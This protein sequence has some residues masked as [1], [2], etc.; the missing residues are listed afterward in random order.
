[1][2]QFYLMLAIAAVATYVVA[3][4]TANWLARPGFPLPPTDRRLGCVDGLRGYL[5]ISVFIHH[6][7][8]W[9]QASRPGGSWGPPSINILNQL[10]AGSVAL[11]FMTTGLVFYPR[12]L[13]A[14][15]WRKVYIT[16]I[17]RIV[18]LVAASVIAIT[19]LIML[20]TGVLPGSD[21]PLAAATWISTWAEPPLL[22][23]VDSGRMNAHVLWSLWYEW[24]FYLLILPACAGAMIIVQ[25][26][27]LPTWVTPVGL[28]SVGIGAQ[29]VC[30][31]LG[32]FIVGFRYIPLFAVGML[33]FELRSR[34]SVRA[35]LSTRCVAVLAVA[36]LLIGLIFTHKP[37]QISLPLFSFFFVC[38]S[39]GNDL[40]G[41]LRSR[42][43]LVLGECSFSIYVLHGILLD[44][45]FVDARALHTNLP[46][47]SLPVLLPLAVIAVVMVT[48]ATYLMIERPAMR[49]GKVLANRIGGPRVALDSRQ[50]DVAP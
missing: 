50:L 32:V 9:T 47:A 28:L 48:L 13:A 10:G 29:A 34:P 7:Y 15:S 14:D 27:N 18:P 24:L 36:A 45:L 33:A 31:L 8:V 1:M 3:T 41:L 5:A 46:Y 43:A 12:V 44:V 26:R 21:Y 40:G 6:F 42:G 16:R 25:A 11:F 19:I 17:F 49:V 20:R 2:S 23:F 35:A 22:G 39:C 38:V 37:Y 30:K 4:L